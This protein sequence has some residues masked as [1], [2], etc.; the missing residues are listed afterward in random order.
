MPVIVKIF[1][2]NITIVIP[3]LYIRIIEIGLYSNNTVDQTENVMN[4]VFAKE[5]LSKC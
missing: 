5:T 1:Y 4:S 2:V 3:T